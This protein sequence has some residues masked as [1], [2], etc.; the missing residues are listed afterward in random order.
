M[1]RTA[2]PLALLDLTLLR[3]AS[4]TA[5]TKP[6]PKCRKSHLGLV[7]A[8]P[9]HQ[10]VAAAPP[11]MEYLPEPTDQGVYSRRRM[12]RRRDVKGGVLAVRKADKPVTGLNLP[13]LPSSIGLTELEK[14]VLALQ[15]TSLNE[16]LRPQLPIPTKS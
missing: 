3:A 2:L 13:A 14:R 9:M 6:L 8:R 1:S 10:A 12:R 4:R 15:N 16:S 11:T 7:L 5:G